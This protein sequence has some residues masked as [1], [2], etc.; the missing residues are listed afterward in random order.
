MDRSQQI[1]VILYI[2]TRQTLGLFDC[3]SATVKDVVNCIK[4]IILIEV[5]HFNTFIKVFITTALK[6]G[7]HY[8]R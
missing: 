1:A 2:R 7:F 6:P 5:K 3:I 4:I 8:P